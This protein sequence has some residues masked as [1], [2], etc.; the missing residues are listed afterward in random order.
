MECPICFRRSLRKRERGERER[1]RERER[2]RERGGVTVENERGAA[3]HEEWGGREE[4]RMKEWRKKVG[5]KKGVEE[6]KS[7]ELRKDRDGR[8]GRK[9]RKN[10]GR[11]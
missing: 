8:T 7:R 11:L 2:E 1:V 4:T 10:E 3:A 5:T 9:E 6:R